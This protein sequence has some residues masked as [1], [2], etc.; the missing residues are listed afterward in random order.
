M[1][2]EFILRHMA[3]ELALDVLG[4][5]ELGR[6]IPDLNLVLDCAGKIEQFLRG[7]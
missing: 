1:D 3:I 6:G 7:K 5:A 4:R 2:R